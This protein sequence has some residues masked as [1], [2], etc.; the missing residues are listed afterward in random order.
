MTEHAATR[1]QNE[2]SKARKADGEFFATPAWVTDAILP[3]VQFQAQGSTDIVVCDPCVGEGAI[4]E[5]V[6]E[7][8][9]GWHAPPSLSGI[10]LHEGRA[11]TAGQKRDIAVRCA[12]A[13]VVDWGKPS[14]VIMNPPFSLTQAFAEK[15]LREVRP[16]GTVAMLARLAFL[17][18]AERYDFH[19]AHPSDAYVFAS[20][21]G[22]LSSSGDTDMSAYAWFA[23][24]PGRGNRWYPLAPTPE[25]LAKARKRIAKKAG[26][27]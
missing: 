19:R 25:A 2:E 13:L 8:G 4:L 6:R 24:G 9:A 16:G 22:F 18:S 23:F 5:R 27:A 3:F 14:L 21:P 20:R 11:L 26:G 10:E 12:D 1:Q 7:W 15:A 17:E